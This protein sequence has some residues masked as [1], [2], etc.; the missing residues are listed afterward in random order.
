V[1][2]S[3]EEFNSK[4]SLIERQENTFYAVNKKRKEGIERITND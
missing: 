3:P 1:T 4:I 2:G